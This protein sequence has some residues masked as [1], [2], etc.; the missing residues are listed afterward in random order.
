MDLDPAGR[1]DRFVRARDDMVEHA[2]TL[3]ACG[4]EFVRHSDERL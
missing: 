4:F 2:N 3:L 1:R